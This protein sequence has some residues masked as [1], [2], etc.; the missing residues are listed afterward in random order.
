MLLVERGVVY[1]TPLQITATEG[2]LSVARL[3]IG[4]G[5]QLNVMSSGDYTHLHRAASKGHLDMVRL[6]IER[7]AI[8]HAKNMLGQTPLQSARDEGHEAVVKYLE[9]YE[10]TQGKTGESA[11]YSLRKSI[12]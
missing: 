12:L 1:E 3:L 7:G 9:K 5:A 11:T 8:T 2:H 10:S 4:R 6:L